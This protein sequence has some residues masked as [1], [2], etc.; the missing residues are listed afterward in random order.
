M[1]YLYFVV[2]ALL[3]L[4]SEALSKQDEVLDDNVASK[5]AV[6]QPR[7]IIYHH[8]GRLSATA[9][10]VFRYVIP[11][12][13]FTD[14]EDG[15]NLTFTIYDFENIP[16]TRKSWLQYNSTS[17][18]F[19]GLPL[20]EHI[21]RWGYILEAK[22]SEGV[23]AQM[24]IDIRVHRQRRA[25]LTNHQF[26]MKVKLLKQFTNIIDWQI[27]A[28]EGIM[29]LFEDSN[30]DLTVLT[31]GLTQDGDMYEFLWAN[32]TLINNSCPIDDINKLM[33]IMESETQPGSPSSN[34]IKAMSPD[35]QV[36]EIGSQ[37]IG[38]CSNNDTMTT[39][40]RM[41][42]RPLLRNSI[43]HLTATVGHL[44]VYNVPEDTFFDL[45]D[46]STRNLHL[47]FKFSDNSQ[48]PSS[49]WLQFD[50]QKQEFYGVPSP[51]DISNANY[52]LIAEDSS[53]KVAYNNFSVEVKMA[54]KI[55]CPTVQ[56]QV[57]MDPSLN[58][59]YNVRNKRKVVEKLLRLFGQSDTD[60]I[61]IE[62]ITDNSSTITLYN[63]SLGSTIQVETEELHKIFTVDEEDND[64]NPNE[65]VN[66][67]VK[68]DIKITSFHL[69]PQGSCTD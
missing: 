31:Y 33:K 7:P 64:M 53:K 47:S 35:L 65:H 21:S 11:P 10:K 61:R 55:I 26:I 16:L 28:L 60:S 37:G 36:L 48:I 19:Y 44:F 3:L 43:G 30:L 51:N 4:S 24:S 42:F 63:K 27:R 8:S 32:D 41:A 23:V 2:F 25:R 9:G 66:Q 57:T 69:I 1:T 58:L 20:I 22:D 67:V 40:T 49:H 18:M 38:R 14:S 52:L 15:S 45:E 5:G 39:N 12:N 34:L 13:V 68:K 62:N 46:G 59:L 6:S 29:T 50:A 54:P 56:F 17:R